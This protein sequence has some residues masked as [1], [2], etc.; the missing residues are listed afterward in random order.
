MGKSVYSKEQIQKCLDLYKS[1]M[2]IE[3]ISKE[4]GI[5]RTSI[6]YI[7]KREGLQLRRKRKSTLLVCP[8]CKSKVE[9]KG[10]KFCPFCGND[11]RNEN[12]VLIDELRHCLCLIQNLPCGDEDIARKT[13]F[14]VI[15]KL[16]E[17]LK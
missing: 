10:A 3:E 4:T 16:K 12:E 8:N 1:G 2:P 6:S 5:E 11:V 15:D 13:I 17:G 9:I 14:K 7:A